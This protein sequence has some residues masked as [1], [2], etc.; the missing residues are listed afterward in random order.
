MAMTPHLHG[1]IIGYVDGVQRMCFY[2][3]DPFRLPSVRTNYF[4]KIILTKWFAILIALRTDTS[5]R[6]L[7]WDDVRLEDSRKRLVRDTWD[8]DAY[9][10]REYIYCMYINSSK[11]MR[12]MQCCRVVKLIRGFGCHFSSHKRKTGWKIVYSFWAPI[13]ISFILF[14]FFFFLKF[15]L[16]V[17]VCLWLLPLRGV[18]IRHITSGSL[19]LQS[20]Q[21]LRPL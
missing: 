19:S 15:L 7:I 10:M 18:I 9:V 20:R 16:F 2:T 21:Q 14:F 3:V 8:G 17:C 4:S 6:S 11:E 13:R 5:S 12:Y 1:D